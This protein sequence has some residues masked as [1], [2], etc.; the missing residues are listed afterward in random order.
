MLQKVSKTNAKRLL[1]TEDK[2]MKKLFLNNYNISF[3]FIVVP[4]LFLVFCAV[5]LHKFKSENPK[6]SVKFSAFHS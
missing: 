1:L 3:A 4:I 6:M 2:E 5:R